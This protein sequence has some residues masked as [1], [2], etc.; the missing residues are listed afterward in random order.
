VSSRFEDYFAELAL[1]DSAT[2]QRGLF[3]HENGFRFSRKASL[4]LTYDARAAGSLR[5][6]VESRSTGESAGGWRRDVTPGR[7]VVRLGTFERD[8]YLLHAFIAGS[9]IALIPFASE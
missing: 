3:D 7:G 4:Q 9:R 8:L 2:L 6:L 5:L 1:E